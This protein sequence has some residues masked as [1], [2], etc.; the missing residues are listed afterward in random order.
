VV[1]H[2]PAEAAAALALAGARGVILLSAPA[3]AESLGPAW[4]LALVRQA[5]AAHP[6]AP[7][8]HAMLLDCGDAPGAALAA[9]RAGARWLVLDPGVPAFPGVA[10]AAAEVGARVW[11]ARPQALDLRSVDLRR[12]AGRARLAAW[13]ADQP[14]A[15][16]H[17]D[18]AHKPAVA[19]P[20]E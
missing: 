12:P 4:F 19:G 10:G 6:G 9:L 14:A 5:V 15:A 16:A 8:P 17:P 1:V 7:P 3:A 13:L 18:A 2:A 20:A 11:P